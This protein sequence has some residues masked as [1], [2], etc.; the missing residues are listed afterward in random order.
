VTTPHTPSAP[1]NRG[2]ERAERAAQITKQRCNYCKGLIVWAKTE[3]KHDAVPM[4]LDYEPDDEHGNALLWHHDTWGLIVSV[5]GTKGA[6]QA[7]VAEGHRLRL[8]HRLSCPDAEKWTT[9]PATTRP[10]KTYTRRS[11]A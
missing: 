9:R 8:H 5:L 1:V 10:K 2:A 6:R 3:P 11:R 7:S 4:P